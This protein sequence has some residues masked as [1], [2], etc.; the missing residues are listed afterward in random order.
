[1]GRFLSRRELRIGVSIAYT[2]SFPT[3]GLE[4]EIGNDFRTLIIAALTFITCAADKRDDSP[5]RSSAS[6]LAAVLHLPQHQLLRNHRQ[7]R[8]DGDQV[9]RNFPRTKLQ[10]GGTANTEWSKMN[11]AAIEEIQKLKDTGDLEAGRLRR[12]RDPRQDEKQA[13][14]MF[15]WAKMGIEVL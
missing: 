9:S 7:G 8:G 15:E 5:Q 1:M 11:E 13:R 3:Q 2:K 6:A 4:S 14:A 12:R 10:P